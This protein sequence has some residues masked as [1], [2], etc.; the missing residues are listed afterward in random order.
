MKMQISSLYFGSCQAFTSIRCKLDL[1][2]AT[3]EQDEAKK[4]NHLKN[5]RSKPEMTRTTRE[6]CVD[7][8]RTVRFFTN[9][10]TLSSG[11]IRIQCK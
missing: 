2:T 1:N 5:T 10:Y 8:T 7:G 11:H 9:D 4:K 3:D 6:N